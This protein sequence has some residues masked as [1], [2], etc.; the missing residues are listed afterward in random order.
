IMA[1]VLSVE[2]QVHSIT[3]AVLAPLTGWLADLFGI[4]Y[5]LLLIC[6]VAILISPLILLPMRGKD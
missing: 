1:S 4:G 2:S 5:A 3:A 6:G